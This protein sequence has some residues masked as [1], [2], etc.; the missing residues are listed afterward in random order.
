MN[1]QRKALEVAHKNP[2][3]LVLGADTLVALGPRIYGKPRSVGEA[4]EMLA[5]LS[6]REHEVTTGVSLIHSTTGRN[7]H[8]VEHTKVKFKSLPAEIIEEYIRT[9]PVL[10]KAGAY[11]I[12]ERGELLVQEI[13][14]SFSNVMGLPI[15]RLAPIL[16]NWGYS[17]R[18]R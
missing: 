18:S 8:F 7:E 2:D 11:G 3:A 12:Q 9:V 16:K 15:E 1:A 6:G 14:G 13:D 4:R 17:P 10:D 5:Q